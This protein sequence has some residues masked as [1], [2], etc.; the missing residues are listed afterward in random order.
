M[1]G[2]MK[3]FVFGVGFLFGIAGAALFSGTGSSHKS[4]A[5]AVPPPASGPV[6][7]PPA[8]P[9]PA[10]TI[11][12]SS[13]R[14]AMGTVEDVFRSVVYNRVELG[15]RSDGVVVWRNRDDWPAK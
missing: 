7:A 14:V 5:V 3:A 11:E 6:V 8:A 12:W 10:T 13:C 9:G 4:A 2:S 15:L 1:T